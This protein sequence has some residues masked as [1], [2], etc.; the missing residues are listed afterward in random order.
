[1]QEGRTN[2][3][4]FSD[5][6]SEKS[7]QGRLEEEE[8]LKVVLANLPKEITETPETHSASNLFNVR[9][10]KER[11]LLDETRAQA[12]HHT[13]AQLLFTGIRCRKDAQKVIS[14]LMMRVRKPDKDDWKKLR[15]FLG[16]LK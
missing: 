12:F 4:S 11:E 13:V 9:Y 14:F 15:I 8:Y 3:D 16:Y 2:V 5:D 10:N 1:M 6:E 7:G